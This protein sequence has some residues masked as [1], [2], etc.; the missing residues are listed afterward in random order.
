MKVI[1]PSAG[2]GTR[3]KPHTHT[4]PKPMV[5]VAG[6][7]IIGHILDRLIEINPE[8]VIIVVGY[9]KDTVINYVSKNYINKF[10]KI[11]F[12]YQKQRL[13]LGHSIYVCKSAVL[14][15][16]IL[17]TLGDMIFK[18]GYMYFLKEHLRNGETTGSIGVKMV[19]NPQHYG[20][21]E[22]KNNIVKGLIEK[23]KV[24]KSNLA[25]AGVYFITD[26]PFLFKI[27][28]YMIENKIVGSGKEYQLTDALE[29][30]V[31][32]GAVFKTFEVTEW[33]DCGRPDT[34]LE[35]NRILLCEK[36]KD[37]EIKSCIINKPVAIG[38]EVIINNS[39]IGPNVSIADNTFIE[40]SIISDS[41]IGSGSTVKNVSL[42]HSLIGDNV[43]LEGKYNTLN[44]GDSSFVQF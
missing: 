26:T 36:S 44:I 17:I 4:K 25:I 15:S 3:L 28:E 2:V 27:L 23:P 32:N 38:K 1:I 42:I 35:A 34:L 41:I 13:G 14:D 39:I 10:N 33:Y 30:M 20:I 22:L 6:K 29:I 16:P 7:Q 8:E 18:E 9:M 19:D 21:V 12:V 5:Y 43:Q 37:L 31:E 11:S 24:S 40:N